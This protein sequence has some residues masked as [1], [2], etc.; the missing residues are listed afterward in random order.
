MYHAFSDGRDRGDRFTV[1]KRAFA[2]QMRLLSILRYRVI[3]FEELARALREQRAL[4]R[5]TAV[6]TIDDG[7]IDNARVAQPIL[8]RHDFPATL[9]L[10]SRRL[11]GKNDWDEEGELRE[12]PLLSLD[13]V[14]AMRRDNIEIGAHT[15]THS[16][17]PDL[18]D[19][20][21]VQEIEGSRV[22]LESALGGPITTFAYPFGRLDDRVVAIVNRAGY[23]GACTVSPRLAH[24]GGDPLRIPRLEVKASDSITRFLRKLWLGG[25]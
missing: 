1:P 13:A 15:E 2:R 19:K 21:A 5:R 11:G 4:P 17:L 3:S 9:F 23:L 8:R 25:P 6:I 22:D 10:V 16:S 20:V 7:Y 14:L 12:R 24:F 18:E